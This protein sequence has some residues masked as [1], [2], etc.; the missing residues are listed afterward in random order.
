[1]H[2]LIALVVAVVLVA[3]FARR[4]RATRGCRWRADSSGDRGSLRKYNCTSCGAEAFTA[5]NGPP[6][7]CKA[8]NKPSSL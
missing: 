7:S 8:K 2:F 5:T 6:D 4:G 3:V 1:M